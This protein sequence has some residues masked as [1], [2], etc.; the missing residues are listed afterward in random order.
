LLQQVY[1]QWYMLYQNNE[2]WHGEAAF[3]ALAAVAAALDAAAVAA[4]L[5]AAAVAAA[6]DA[7]DSSAIAG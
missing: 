4:A 1:R 2:Q 3:V 6:L 5:D 7:E